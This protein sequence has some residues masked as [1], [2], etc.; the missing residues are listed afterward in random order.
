MALKDKLQDLSQQINVE[1]E[2]K[3]KNEENEKLKPI[4]AEIKKKEKEIFDLEIIKN[5]LDF[6]GEEEKGGQGMSEYAKSTA[7]KKKKA[8]AELEGIANANSEALE[9]MG[10]KN[11]DGLVSNPEFAEE[12]EV[13]AYKKA[14]GQES[15]LILSDTKLKSRLAKLGIEINDD[16]FSYQT[17]SEEIAK[18]LDVLNNELMVEKIKTPEGKEEVEEMLAKHFMKEIPKMEVEGMWKNV[19]GGGAESVSVSMN[20]GGSKREFEVL[21]DKANF[22]ASPYF[23]YVLP[24]DFSE[25]VDKYGMEFA[26]GA[27]KKAYSKKLNRSFIE[28]DKKINENSR[29]SLEKLKNI[30]PEEKS[31]AMRLFEKFKNKKKEVLKLMDKKE[32]EAKE[33]G[34]SR[35]LD[36]EYFREMVNFSKDRDGHHQDDA[37]AY[38]SV[39]ESNYNGPNVFPPKYDYEKL[40]HFI[41]ERIEKIEDFMQVLANFNLD[42][43][44]IDDRSMA[45]Y[46]FD[47]YNPSSHEFSDITSRQGSKT[48][49]DFNSYNSAQQY[50]REKVKK[51]EDVEKN[52]SEKI[53]TLVELEAIKFEL[54]I[55]RYK[56][57]NDVQDA[58]ISVLASIETEVERSNRSRAFASRTLDEITRTEIKLPDEEAELSGL[59]LHFPKKQKEIDEINKDITRMEG[60]LEDKKSQLSRE[61]KSEPRLFGKGKWQDKI[62]ALE[63]EIEDIENKI[64]EKKDSKKLKEKDANRTWT[65]FENYSFQEGPTTELKRMVTEHKKTGNSKEIFNELKRKLEEVLNE[66]FPDDIFKKYKKALDLQAKVNERRQ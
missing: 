8:K 39:F 62:S 20:I 26:T 38:M 41:N 59:Y 50:F 55:N 40:Q 18:R 4:R 32:K 66:K 48:L 17:A 27:L 14:I 19:L 47:P 1:K 23:D 33:K 54:Y 9:R 36:F 3:K 10:V 21:N 15:D 63:K 65:T 25:Q 46:G 12:E 30:S 11:I 7:G 37:Q 45:L 44:R 6:K 24:K 31:K 56:R 13:V 57:S 49:R 52:I 43:D 64:K 5:S 2:E 35:V 53:S 61:K 51:I 29:G 60:Q 42:E 58:Y 16:N 28:A 34:I 22:K